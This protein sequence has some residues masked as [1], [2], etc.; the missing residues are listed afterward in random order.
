MDPR[1]NPFSP[2]AGTRPPALTGRDAQLEQFD[3]L[4]SRL[5]QG[6]SGRSML[7]TGLRGVGKTVLLN[8]FEAMA[9]E[10][11]W[12]TASREITEATSLPDEIA[13]IAQRAIRALSVTRKVRSRVDELLA[14][15]TGF[16]V[17]GPEGLEISFEPRAASR[18]SAADLGD[19][20][21]DLFCAVGEVAL[22]KDRGVVVLLDEAQF[23]DGPSL[24]ALLAGLHRVA[25]RELPFAVVGA[26]L[27]QLPR[28][29]GEAKSYAERLFTFPSLGRLT[30]AAA[31]DALRIPAERQG[32][33]FEDAAIARTL[34]VTGRY[35]YFLQE[36]GSVAWNVARDGR[37]TAGDVATA[38]RIVTDQL[39]EGFF[40]I[41]FERATQNER[42]YL[43]A[44]AELGDGPQRS[45]VIAKALGKSASSLSPQRDA[46]IRK[47]LIYAPEHGTLDFTVPQFA[48]YLRRTIP[49]AER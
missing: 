46:L 47:G 25:Q 38:E 26:G 2:G 44:M 3:V 24:E 43:R 9:Q 41:R 36:Y 22:A 37:I 32:V 10:R 1:E 4:L 5:A 6:R 45:G 34:D 29:A 20:F 28:L 39:D 19:D 35:P 49:F 15:L 40:R 11:G 8:T 30:D 23:L 13:R 16:T 7:V 17:S 27:P 12:Y 42:R 18:T 14:G 33:A 21:G 48:A 31:A